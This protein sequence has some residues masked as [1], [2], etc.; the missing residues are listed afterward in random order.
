VADKSYLADLDE[1]T[2][3]K[4]IERLK[5]TKSISIDM[6]YDDIMADLGKG[7]TG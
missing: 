6:E 2:G 7:G 3:R 1:E 5:R 4:L